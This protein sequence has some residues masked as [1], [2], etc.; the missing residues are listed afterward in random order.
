MVS[1][2]GWTR[3]CSVRRP[4]RWVDAGGRRLRAAR[5]SS[6]SPSAYRPTRPPAPASA[7]TCDARWSPAVSTTTSRACDR[8]HA[9]RS[10]APTWPTG[11]RRHRRSRGFAARSR[12]GDGG[13]CR[14]SGPGRAG[15]PGRRAARRL[16]RRPRPRA[17]RR[18][19]RR[20]RGRGAARHRRRRRGAA[21]ALGRARRRGPRGRDRG[22]GRGRRRRGPRR[23]REPARGRLRPPGRGPRRP[24]ARPPGR[25]GR[26]RPERRVSAPTTIGRIHRLDPRTASRIAAGE[27]LD[28]PNAALKELVE[29][30]LDADARAIDV[31]VEGSLDRAFEVADDGMGLSP[32][33]LP[34]CLER[35]ATSKIRAL[36]DLD[37][38]ATLGFRGEALPSIA[39]VSRFAILSRPRE[40]GEGHRIE[41]E[42]GVIAGIMPAAR[43]PGTTVEVRDLF[44]NTPA[45]RRFLKAPGSEL[46]QA[47]RMLAS[48]ALG[49]PEVAFRF[50][51]DGRSRLALPVAASRRERLVALYGAPF[52]ERL[53]EVREERP[54]FAFEAWLGVPEMARVTR[55][56]Q[57]MLINRRWIQSPMLS[58]AVRHGYGNL[59]PPGRHP[60]AIL[61]LELDPAS[62]DV[63]V[64]P[65]KREVR[66]SREDA[67]FGF[68]AQTVSRPMA[69]LAPRYAPAGREAPGPPSLADLTH[70]DRRQPNLFAA[71]APRAGDVAGPRLPGGLAVVA[72]G[73]SLAGGTGALAP[74][75]GLA[76]VPGAAEVGDEGGTAAAPG[77]EAPA[78]ARLPDL[79]QLHDTY[80]LA[81]IAG[82]LLIVDQH[83]AHERILYEE[84]RARFAGRETA[85]QGLLFSQ[86]VDLSRDQFDLVLE[87]MPALEKLGFEIGA[88]S[89][90][91]VLVRSV[92]AG[93]GPHDAGVL[94]RDVLDGLGE[95]HGR[96]MAR[97]E[98]WDRV[99]KSFACHAAVRAG[100]RLSRESM[101]HL[102]D[103]LFA[104]ELPHGDP[105]GRPTFVRVDLH[106]LNQ[107]FGRSDG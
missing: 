64:H 30:A 65:T 79:W 88:L 105:H 10:C 82:G 68:V 45:R 104:T 95:H 66:F 43:A 9:S 75:G 31:T 46:R 70:E 34:V 76:L 14:R 23:R 54:G 50:V 63:N 48:Y 12:R 5:S 33:E 86:A 101:N 7:R 106:E 97:D 20:A 24:R 78:S 13:T 18:R 11:R 6:R 93:I 87:I 44:Y 99:A 42:G 69:V 37:A 39:E 15:R 102:V 51:V 47:D 57:T 96:S 58:Q 67:V 55:E 25:T 77:E 21:L 56:G 84:A 71:P 83:A 91:G 89:P 16:P 103:R 59:I 74:G 61:A 107:R 17:R 40:G 60:T 52:V 36:E 4:S 2:P 3:S 8:A 73:G 26:I 1:C 35:H 32:D 81:P 92:P 53:L 19:G 90:P 41:V 100:D 49:H 27:V 98:P 29:N 62:V 72:G 28:R 94:L 80:I 38:L 85:S 22:A